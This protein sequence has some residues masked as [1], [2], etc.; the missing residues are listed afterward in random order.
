MIKNFVKHSVRLQDSLASLASRMRM[1]EEEL[2]EFH[3][4]NCGKMDKLWFT[5]LRGIKCILI[6]TDYISRQNRTAQEEN[7]LPSRYFPGFHGSAYFVSEMLK[8]NDQANLKINYTVDLR[9]LNDR[10]GFIAKMLLKDFRKNGKIPDDKV[11]SLSLACMDKIYPISYALSQNGTLRSCL[12]GKHL[13]E[14]FK[15]ERAFLE[16]FFIG[17]ISKIY[18]DLFAENISDE[19]Y[20]FSQIQSGLLYQTLFPDLEWFHKCS[21]WIKKFYIY[22]HTFPLKFT[23]QTEYIF[24]HSHFIE[25]KLTGTLSEDCSLRELLRGIRLENEDP[26]DYIRAEIQMQYS[27]HKK[28]RQLHEVKSSVCIWHQ[29]KLFRKHE[30]RLTQK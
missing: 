18:L 8:R 22:S 14:K 25:I 17:K 15:S 24:N 19:N 3:N 20:F 30:L 6:P 4:R 2:K 28:N 16:E 26:D 7:R 29:N 12:D 23:C 11:S 27:I 10:E 1:T 21:A 9:V 13:I 5:N